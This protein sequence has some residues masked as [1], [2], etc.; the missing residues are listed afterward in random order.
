MR[1]SL[2]YEDVTSK[3]D[4]YSVIAMGLF[5]DKTG[6]KT[7]YLVHTWF[8][9]SLESCRKAQKTKNLH[10]ESLSLGLYA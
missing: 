8:T 7:L 6:S 2:S 3:A 4:Q 10:S 5:P 9:Q 1:I